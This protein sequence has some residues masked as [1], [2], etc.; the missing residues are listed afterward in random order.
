MIHQLTVIFDSF[1]R[2]HK[3]LYKKSYILLYILLKAACTVAYYYMQKGLSFAY[4]DSYR[5]THPDCTQIPHPNSPMHFHS[6]YSQF[7]CVTDLQ[8]CKTIYSFFA[9]K[10]LFHFVASSCSVHFLKCMGHFQWSDTPE[11]TLA[12]SL[13]NC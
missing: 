8:E 9:L 7:L 5:K 3:I 2:L 11:T 1:R 6:W 12:G 13:S 10:H 4:K